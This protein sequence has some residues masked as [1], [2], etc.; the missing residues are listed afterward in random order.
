M[1]NIFIIAP[2]G[3][4]TSQRYCRQLK[5]HACFSRLTSLTCLKARDCWKFGSFKPLSTLTQLQDLTAGG[6][7]ESDA[8]MDGLEGRPQ[9]S[10]GKGAA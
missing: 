1:L 3:L 7:C 8:S 4:R 9:D 10:T 5:A 6:T 2:L